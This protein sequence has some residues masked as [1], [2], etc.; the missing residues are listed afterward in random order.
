MAGLASIAVRDADEP[1]SA[2]E[3]E[4][5]AAC[6]V[7]T[8]HVAPMLGVE[9]VEDVFFPGFTTALEEIGSSRALATLRALGAVADSSHERRARAAA[10][11]L[12]ARGVREPPWS[13]GLGSARPV[14]AALMHDETFDD[15]LSVLVEFV[16]DDGRHTL[17]TYIDNNMGGL[18]KD[19]FVAGPLSEVRDE[20]E[21]GGSDEDG[22]VIRDLG[23]DEARARVEAALEMLDHTYEP[24]VSDDV[25]MLRAL[26]DA[27]MRLLPR[28]FEL[29]DDFVEMTPDERATMLEGFLAS[30]E[31][32]KW[33]GDE[34]A[35]DVAATAI[36]FGADYNHGGPLRWS[37]VVVE[38]FMTSWLPRKIAREPEF[39]AR[40]PDVLRTWVAYAGR[41]RGLAPKLKREAVAAVKELS[42]EMLEA[43][44]DPEAWGPAK[45]FAVAAQQAGVDLQ[46]PAAVQRF[47]DDYN[48]GLAA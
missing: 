2:L 21:G 29:P 25:R 8:W 38:I 35:E 26:I 44:A 12:A 15:G 39:F 24:P 11:R 10:D 14:A 13:A 45:T 7:G 6:L 41:R 23:L 9:R 33:A 16:D 1:G 4:Q 42:D 18:V 34:D 22:I 48:D 5:W 30:R 43:V 19:A 37:P 47:I 40:V 27:R 28:G 17:G 31:G 36:D 3:A 32:R 46:D 20:L